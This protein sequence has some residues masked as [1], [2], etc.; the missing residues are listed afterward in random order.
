[1]NTA[2]KKLVKTI[3]IGGSGYVAAELV[4]LIISHPQLELSAVI[5]QS[6]AGNRIGLV[7]PHLSQ[8]LKDKKFTSIKTLPEHLSGKIALF[9]AAPHG[10]SAGVI[11]N[12]L[13]KAKEK[14]CQ[15][16]IVDVSADFRFNSAKAW[17]S[18][19]NQKHQAPD[20]FKKFSTGLP[21]HSNGEINNHIGHPG[22]FATAMLLSAIPILDLDLVDPNINA[23]GITGSSGSGQLPIETTHHPFRHGNLYAYKPLNHRHADEVIEMC[24]TAIGIKPKLNFI[25]H[26]GPFSRGI[27]MTIQATLRNT[28]TT[29]NIKEK[30]REYYADSPFVSIVSG[31]PRLKDVVGSNYA[32]IGVEVNGNTL[33]MFCVIDNLIKGAAGGAIQWMN[34]ILNIDETIGLDSTS[35]G[36]L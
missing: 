34:R 35:S 1:M 11:N 25:P 27:Y 32:Q 24:S 9:S 21:E 36:W 2:P 29:E 12:A 19:Y 14:N 22:C 7:F 18:V 30:L 20:L 33:V 6:Q 26:S 15:L 10:A 31:A 17:E 8:A 3:V 28:S 4:R 16:N 23:F 13:N 5:S